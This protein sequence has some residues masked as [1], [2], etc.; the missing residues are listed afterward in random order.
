MQ[1][2]ADI[3]ENFWQSKDIILSDNQMLR[4]AK[5][6]ID[7]ILEDLSEGKITVC[8]KL[9]EKWQVNEW[10]K[11]AILLAF[12]LNDTRIVEAGYTNWFDKI[13]QKFASYSEQDFKNEQFR[14]VPGCFVRKGVYI[15]QNAVI[16]PSF[17]NIGAYIG[18]GTMIDSFVTVGSCAYI[19]NN[20][21]ISEGVGIGGVL[22]PLQAKPVIVE[23]NC[24]IG[25]KSSIVEG[26]TVEEGAVIG[27]GVF[28]SSSTKIVNRETKEVIYGRIPAYSVVVSGCMPAKSAD[29]PSLYCAVIVKKVDKKT[30]E[31]TALNELL[32]V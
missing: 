12:K 31:K 15:G 16:M 11:K 18:N 10:V 28:I 14:A 19:G 25:V 26:V 13:E 24:F 17:L 9:D 2:Y 27:S 21:H 23:D 20:C 5:L 22:E 32:R 8:Q 29:L 3:V 1:N 6:I 7:D 4:Q 30:R